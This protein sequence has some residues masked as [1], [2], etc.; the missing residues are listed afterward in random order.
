VAVAGLVPDGPAA[1][2]GVREGDLIVAVNF[3]EVATRAAVYDHLWKLPAGAVARLGILRD[4]EHVIVE[5]A[6]VDRAEF[7]R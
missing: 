3:A 6:S 2:A 5:V 4:G 7:Y 1:R